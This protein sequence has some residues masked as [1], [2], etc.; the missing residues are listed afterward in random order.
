MVHRVT[1]SV[2]VT[3]KGLIWNRRGLIGKIELAKQELVF[4]PITIMD[5]G[6]LIPESGLEQEGQRMTTTRVET[7]VAPHTSKPWGTS[8]YSEERKKETN[9]RKHTVL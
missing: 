4:S 1:Y 3:K 8:W 7:M 5:A 9:K 2:S 6:M